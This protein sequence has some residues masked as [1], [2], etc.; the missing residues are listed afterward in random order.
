MIH[1]VIKPCTDEARED[2]RECM[3][4][5]NQKGRITRKEERKNCMH[6]LE[7]LRHIHIVNACVT[8]KRK[9]KP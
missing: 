5:E 3:R 6:E 9:S 2:V 1:G 4:E 7:I 8:P